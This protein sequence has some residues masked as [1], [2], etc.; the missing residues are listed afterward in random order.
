MIP[1]PAGRPA[2]SVVIASWTGTEE[3]AR[4]LS[5][6]LDQVEPG[7]DEIIIARN[8]SLDAL[9]AGQATRPGVIDLPLPADTSVP[10]LRAAGLAAS[11]GSIIAFIEDHCICQPGWRSAIV[12]EHELACDAV[13][14]PVDLDE[15]GGP[16]DWAVYFYDYAKFATPVKPGPVSSLSGANASYKRA[17]LESVGAELRTL[18]LEVTIERS[19]RD[20]GL[21]MHLAPGASVV[22]RKQHRA[23]KIVPLTF[24]L[25]RGYAAHRLLGATMPKRAAFAAATVVLPVLLAAR[26]VAATLRAP[27]H[28]WRL[29]LAA[30]WLGVLLA[31]WS[32][33]ELAGYAAGTGNSLARWR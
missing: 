23:W 3:L 10:R 16:L 4:S 29:A 11:R 2:L 28:S 31:T 24:A 15:E 12:R 5:S 32:F 22:S 6:L 7:R 19:F 8:F 9:V 26:I 21:T 18:V 25:A 27:R 30:P 14:G 1:G 20:R 13:G 33:G 17:A